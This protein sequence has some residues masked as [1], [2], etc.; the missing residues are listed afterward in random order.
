MTKICTTNVCFISLMLILL[1]IDEFVYLH[2]FAMVI[3][4]KCIYTGFFNRIG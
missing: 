4:V 3:N 1:D 2:F